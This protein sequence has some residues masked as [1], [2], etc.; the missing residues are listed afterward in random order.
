MVVDQRLALTCPCRSVG[1][2][3]QV[4]VT[5]APP[6]MQTDSASLGQV[7]EGHAVQTLPLNG[8]NVLGLVSLVPGVVPLGNATGVGN[9]S[10]N[11][12]GLNVF[13]A[14]N[15]QFSGA[16]ANQGAVLVDGAPVNTSYGNNV[17]LV[18]D[19]DSI[20]E[21]NVQT[22]NNTAEF[23]MYNGGV[24]N[25]ST[26]SGT[27]AFHG[28]AYEYVRNTCSTLITSLPIERARA[29]RHGTRTSSAPILAVLSSTINSSSS[30]TTRVIG[31]PKASRPRHRPYAGGVDGRLLRH[32]RSHLRSAHDL[33]LQ[34]QS[35]LYSGTATIRRSAAAAV[36]L[37]RRG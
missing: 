35:G 36:L 30:A 23:G 26:R 18:M 6:M 24:V 2:A 22:H 31:R 21:F 28:E 37:Q 17:V 19:Q 1:K 12:S 27:N 33:R 14:G 16:D 9:T 11:L 29:D 13:A 34:R 3:R 25:M 8:R 10:S 4:T 7:V 32:H 15:Y 5:A 20:Q